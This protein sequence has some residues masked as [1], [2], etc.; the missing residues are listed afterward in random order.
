MTCQPAPGGAAAAGPTQLSS[1]AAFHAKT[2]GVSA[3]VALLR[4]ALVAPA[5][6][7]ATP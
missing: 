2:S 1:A 6:A 5:G 7:A 4:Q 3:C